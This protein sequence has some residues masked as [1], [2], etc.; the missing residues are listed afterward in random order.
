MEKKEYVVEVVPT[1]V[2]RGRLRAPASRRAKLSI[3]EHL[4]NNFE[5][6]P[7]PMFRSSNTSK[8]GNISTLKIPEPLPP[9]LHI[10]DS[11]RTYIFQAHF[12]A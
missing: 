11:C 4:L 7:S 2:S 12:I 6:E 9:Y 3:Q 1:A 5:G 8:S 10:A